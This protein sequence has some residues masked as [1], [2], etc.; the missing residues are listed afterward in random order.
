MMARVWENH[1][2]LFL[3]PCSGL[4]GKPGWDC[5]LLSLWWQRAGTVKRTGRQKK[6][7]DRVWPSLRVLW[8]NCLHL[9]IWA[10]SDS[11]QI[12][13][14]S[15]M[16]SYMWMWVYLFYR[17]SPHLHSVCVQHFTTNSFTHALKHH[18]WTVFVSVWP[19]RMF[20][21]LSGVYPVFLTVHCNFHL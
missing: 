21:V 6:G 2:W 13:L 11:K 4:T 9:L 12:W 14:F 3:F 15:F 20:F 7:E 10:K 16:L 17:I 18:K 1:R 5:H 8:R 19:W